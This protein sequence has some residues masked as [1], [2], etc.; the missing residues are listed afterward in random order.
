[1]G[2]IGSVLKEART[3]KAVSLEEVHAKIKIH[4][5]V[6]Q[7]LEEDKFD[8]LPSPLFVKSFLKSYA[9]FLDLSGDELL[10][11]YHKQGEKAPEQVLF[12]KTADEREHESKPN[13]GRFLVLGAVYFVIA[14]AAVGAVLYFK[15]HPG[16]LPVIRMPQFKAKPA[17]TEA[18]VHQGKEKAAGK[19]KE[20]AEKPDSLKKS[21]EWLRS[22]ALGNFPVIESK[23]LLELKVKAVDTVWLHMTCDG[24]VLYQGILRRGGSEIW[25]A[26]ETIEIWTGNASN[27]F[28]TLNRYPLGS[29]GKGVVKKMIISRQGAKIAAQAN[30]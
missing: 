7:L 26:R 9:D 6:L 3:R 15:S 25:T 27:I 21:N 1:M 28:L 18:A 11:N 4:P 20:T 10:E 16:R 5:R 2:S 29:P 19:R 22:A 24:K 14:V 8:K 13:P 23:T 17:K 12:I 30:P